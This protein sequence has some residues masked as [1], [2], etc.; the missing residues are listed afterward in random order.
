[1]K[2]YYKISALVASKI[3]YTEYLEG[4]AVA[5]AMLKDGTWAVD[6][7]TI[8][9]IKQDRV[10]IDERLPQNSV[11][12]FEESKFPKV[13]IDNSEFYSEFR[14]PIAIRQAE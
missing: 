12:N 2:E 8:D 11:T 9:G 10:K 14:P 7:I 6:A 4:R 13:V 3:G 5:P 1:M